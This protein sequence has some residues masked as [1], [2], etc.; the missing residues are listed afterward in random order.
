MLGHEPSAH[1]PDG[2]GHEVADCASGDRGTQTGSLLAVPST[3]DLLLAVLV[4]R[5]EEGV[6]ERDGDYVGSV[7]CVR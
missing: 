2:V 6:E 7:P 1:N 5:E 4:D 3:R